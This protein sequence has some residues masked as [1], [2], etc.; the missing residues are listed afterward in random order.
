VVD[1]FS[2]DGS[3]EYISTHYP[4]ICLVRNST[5]LGY[6]GG[7]NVGI[8]IALDWGADWVWI[9]NPDVRVSP[10]SLANL[11]A[12]VRPSVGILG[13]KSYFEKGFEFHKQRYQKSQLGKVIW[14][15]GGSIDW[16]NVESKHLGVDQ[17]DQ[18]QF[19]TPGPTEFITGASMLL[20]GQMLKNIGV[21]DEKY[22]LYFEEVDLC[23]RA[24]KANWQLLYVP[25][26]IV[27]HA[28]ALS[29]GSG[30]ALH[31][32]YLIRNKLLFGFRWAPFKTKLALIKF[33]LQTILNGRP[34]QRRGVLDF[35][36]CHLG[37]GS[38]RNSP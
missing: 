6:A 10:D 26:S 33:S 18:G 13:S 3:A 9:V 11:L 16:K 31:D 23:Q 17:V 4:K 20:S 8:R 37:Q 27:W 19:D 2:T 34:W 35:Y 5:N 38:F 24:H 21:F 28:N 30:S 29:S 12:A 14:F 32:Y 7:N 15:A 36:L 22:F 1:N 25:D